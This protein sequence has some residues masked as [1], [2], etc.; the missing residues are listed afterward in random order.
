MGAT[1]EP[2]ANCDGWARPRADGIG[3][4]VP[5]RRRRRQRSGASAAPSDGPGPAAGNGAALTQQPGTQ[6]PDLSRLLTSRAFTPAP[7]VG[8]VAAAIVPGKRLGIVATR[9]AA[10]GEPL[11]VCARPLAALL[12]DPGAPPPNEELVGALLAAPLEPEQ[13]AWLRLLHRGVGGE[14]GPGGAEGGEGGE[15]AGPTAAAAAGAEAAEAGAQEAGPGPSS[16]SDAQ[17]AEDLAEANA[18]LAGTWPAAEPGSS[19]GTGSGS[20]GDGGDPAAPAPPR[21]ALL[22]VRYPLTPEQLERLV[23]RCAYAERS[24]D[25]AA[26]DLKELSPESVAGL[27]PEFALLNHSCAPN[28][29][30]APFGNVLVVRAA[31]PILAGEELT[32]CYLGEPRLAPIRARRAALRAG[33]G[34]HCQCARCVAEQRAFPTNWYPQDAELL[35]LEGASKAGATGGGGGGGGGG[36][37]GVVLSAWQGLQLWFGFGAAAATRP[38][39]SA[40][41]FVLQQLSDAAAEAAPEVQAAAAAP[42]RRTAVA[43]RAAVLA[44]AAAGRARLEAA[45]DG[46]PRPPAPAER[47]WLLASAYAWLR[48]E[49]DALELFLSGG[50]LPRDA[51]IRAAAGA[52]PRRWLSGLLAAAADADADADG[53]GPQEDA[54]RTEAAARRAL[55]ARQLVALSAA[56]AA[57]DGVARGSELHLSTAVA[58]LDAARALHGARS[59]EA[60]AAELAAGVA[61][62][63]RYGPL[64]PGTLADAIAARRR[65]LLGASL[66]RRMSIL[67]WDAAEG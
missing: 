48:L 61:H 36:L 55:R 26:A 41:N 64:E 34:F 59:I 11:L 17:W 19:N 51:D 25:A 43:R 23:A 27:W 63:A 54:E 21:L 22:G 62:A 44:R 50:A 42:G 65:R 33:Y 28:T 37:V 53:E 66:S 31:T 4:P 7:Y 35:G 30:A 20:D 60:R 9:G 52:A 40:D 6:P 15:A 46:L 12:G 24:E 39:P 29:C 5:L 3:A 14:E 13:A 2:P 58:A 10:V 57:L 67:A 56:A 38:A 45:V 32:T 1:R 47:R 16:R 8:P 49:A 18:L